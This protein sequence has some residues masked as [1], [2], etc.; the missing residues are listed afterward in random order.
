MTDAD[1][2]ALIGRRA[3]PLTDAAL[4][5][6]AGAGRIL[7]TGAGGSIGSILVGALAAAG[8][9]D[10]VMVDRDESQLHGLEMSLSREG[11]EVDPRFALADITQPD[12]I[13][14]VVGRAAPDVV[15]H[16]AALKHVPMLERFPREAWRVNVA[17]TL[18]VLRAARAA[19][20]ARLV[21][22]SSDKA[23]EP[24]SVLGRTKAVGERLV[25][26]SGAEAWASVRLAN[27]LGSRGSVYP[28][29]CAQIRAG[30]AI[31][32]THPDV[33]RYFLTPLETA[34]T[35]A[36]AW[37]RAAGGGV[38]ASRIDSACRIRDLAE[39]L[40][41]REG[42]RVPIRYTGLRPGEKLSEDIV[43]ET[44]PRESAGAALWRVTVP[45]LAWDEVDAD[46]AWV[47][48]ESAHTPSP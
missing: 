26:A 18:N 27:V 16:A 10:L 23:C 21:N 25:A 7:V 19:G 28:A 32:L 17:G 36:E 24:T 6:L 42:A 22:L 2:L 43:A 20:V 35:L 5:R 37:D 46:Y 9:D 14:E 13:A 44:E 12:D 29:F 33:E 38:L 39:R 4:T 8:C 15:I 34:R 11:L 48:G 31:T 47:M 41:L 3:L 40:M 45:A 1:A 30:A